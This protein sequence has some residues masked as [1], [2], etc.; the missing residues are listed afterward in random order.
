MKQ[1]LLS[2]WHLMRLV[3]LAFAIFLFFNAYET[4][5]WFF[6]VFGLLFLFQAIFNLGCGANGCGITYKNKNHE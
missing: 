3:R 4:H 5:E 2:N 1:V 6:V